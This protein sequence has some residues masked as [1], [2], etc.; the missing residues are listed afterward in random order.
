IEPPRERDARPAVP[1]GDLLLI[2]SRY[3]ADQLLMLTAAAYLGRPLPCLS[4]VNHPESLGRRLGVDNRLIERHSS[5]ELLGG[6]APCDSPFSQDTDYARPPEISCADL[7]AVIHCLDLDLAEAPGRAERA[8]I[9]E[10]PAVRPVPDPELR[11]EG[12]QRDPDQV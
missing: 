11:P 7:G 9:D 5:D 6:M 4:L 3:L 10:Q 2:S 12:H 8:E 1:Y